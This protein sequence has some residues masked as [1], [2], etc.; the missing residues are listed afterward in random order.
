MTSLRTIIL[1]AGK[2]TRM[3]SSLPKV[4]HQVAGKTII[5][6]VL[7]VAQAVGSLKTYVVV[8][9]QSAQVQNAL[10]DNVD[11]VIQ[12]Q[13][14][15]TA[16]AVRSAAP[17]LQ[18]YHGDVLILCGDTPLLD[19]AVLRRLIKKHRS[20]KAA[21][22]LLSCDMDDPMGYGRIIR[23]HQNNV[24]AIREQK[25]ATSAERLISEINV[26]VYCFNAELLFD[27]L[28]KIKRN[29]KKNEFYL[30]DIIP[31]LLTHNKRVDVFKTSDQRA[32]LGVNTRVQLAEAEAILRKQINETLMLSG[33][34][35]VDPNTTFIDADV[36]IKPDT[37]I[38][39][40]TVIERGVKIGQACQIGPMA[41][42]RQ[43]TVI[44]NNVIVG[45]HTEVSRSVL[46]DGVMMKHM[47]FL[48]DARVG[49]NV[50][51]GAGVITANYDGKNKHQ[52][53]IGEKAFIGTDAVL[54][55]P[56]KI[57]SKAMIGAGS[58]VPKNTKVPPGSL[59]KGVPAKNV[60]DKKHE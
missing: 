59:L 13:L 51:I 57:G 55:A 6:H 52:T 31:H 27:G 45:N 21:C 7:D 10:P 5:H 22:T 58:V 19:K 14:A 32:A 60:K 40:M 42:L 39:P 36:T 23:D 43:G 12:E 53:V 4:L 44:K 17:L 20:T 15:G 35:I 28:K 8:G 11:V 33:V 50:N 25:D 49:K 3:K 9:H 41:R 46:E 38:Y 56:L 24:V 29:A 48:G 2:G 1:A 16:D 18:N 26:G 47:G 30:T 34:T 54:I 37:V